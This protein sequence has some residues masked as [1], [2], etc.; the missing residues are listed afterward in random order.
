MPEVEAALAEVLLVPKLFG[1]FVEF[2]ASEEQVRVGAKVVD[3]VLLQQLLFIAVHH[4]ALAA[5]RE[6]EEQLIED[7]EAELRWKFHDRE[8]EGWV[9]WWWRAL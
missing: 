6:V 2:L 5:D 3:L 1:L 7:H 9:G 4:G 8:G